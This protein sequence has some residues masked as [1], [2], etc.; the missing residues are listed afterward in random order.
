M[1]TEKNEIVNRKV[2]QKNKIFENKTD[3]PLAIL[4]MKK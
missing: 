4:T 2:I 3:D 1:R